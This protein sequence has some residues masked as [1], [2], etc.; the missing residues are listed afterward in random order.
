MISCQRFIQPLLENY[1]T[2]LI[3]IYGSHI[4]SIILYGSY[5][6]GDYTEDSDIDIM[7]LL[8][9]SDIEIKKIPT[10]VFWHDLRF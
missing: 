10:S 4:K 1:V 2:R 3:E 8:D 9:I 6:Q 7:T 5:T